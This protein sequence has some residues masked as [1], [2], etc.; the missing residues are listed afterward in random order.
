MA[1]RATKTRRRSSLILRQEYLENFLLNNQ[2]NFNTNNDDGSNMNNVIHY[3]KTDANTLY[4]FND[5]T[6][7]NNNFILNNDD[8]NL[9][10]DYHDGTNNNIFKNDNNDNNQQFLGWHRNQ[11]G[12]FIKHR[13]PKYYRNNRRNKRRN[14]PRKNRNR[15]ENNAL[16]D[17]QNNGHNNYKTASKKHQNK[18]SDNTNTNPRW[19]KKIAKNHNENNDEISKMNT[20]NN[21]VNKKTNEMFWWMNNN[22]DV[23]NNDG[24]NQNNHNF[25]RN[26]NT[27]DNENE[28]MN[29]DMNTDINPSSQNSQTLMTVNTNTNENI[30]MNINDDNN[31]QKEEIKDKEMLKKNIIEKDDRL[32]VTIL[33]G[34]FGSGKTTLLQHILHNKEGLKVAVIVNDLAEL[35]IDA[36]SIRN[37]VEL[38]RN[39]EKLIE[40]QNG[41]ICCTLRKNLLIE[42]KNLATIK[43]YDYILMESTGISK[44]SET[45]E[46]FDLNENENEDKLSDIVRLDN[47]VAIVD[48]KNIQEYMQSMHKIYEELQIIEKTS[49]KSNDWDKEYSIPYTLINQIMFANTI[50]INKCD[51]VDDKFIIFDHIDFKEQKSQHP[52]IQM[53]HEFCSKLNSKAKII[54]TNYCE[55]NLK[56]IFNTNRFSFSEMYQNN[57]WLQNIQKNKNKEYKLEINKYG[58]TTFIY[59]ARKPFH[60]L[61][62]QLWMQARLTKG[63]IRAKGFVWLASRN[64]ICFDWKQVGDVIEFENGGDWFATIPEKEWKLPA[65]IIQ[66]IKKDFHGHFGDRRQ[67]IVFIGNLDMNAN[68]IEQQLNF[69]LLNNDELALGPNKWKIELPDPFEDDDD[70]DDLS[71]DSN[72]NDENDDDFDDDDDD[73]DDND[74]EE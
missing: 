28:K 25:N 1:Q 73:I 5:F 13:K 8:N 38:L 26:L 53:I 24:N 70:D 9:G 60:P 29:A 12:K 30:N 40:M 72:D 55:I 15:N 65:Q 16:N 3:E 33:S 31:K 74:N 11:N 22:K 61:K 41:C 56:E 46:L 62:L 7:F 57:K 45:A 44:L 59:H 32:P 23:N 68:E 71:G 2:H 36:I 19:Q 43:K 66:Q 64:D 18:N 58:L 10:R 4:N 69:C 51:L 21:S 49:N 63:V 35:N 39:D 48:S 27:N 54:E 34:F 20:T 17:N 14:H 52:T 42:L 37:D 6:N 67:S 50:I 47:M